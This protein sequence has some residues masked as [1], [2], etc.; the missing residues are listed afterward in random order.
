MQITKLI[1]LKFN[2]YII[3]SIRYNV[4]FFIFKYALART[5]RHTNFGGWTEK[6]SFNFLKLPNSPLAIQIPIAVKFTNIKINQCYQ[7]APGS[8]V[9]TEYD[10]SWGSVDQIKNQLFGV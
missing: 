1:Y 3:F 10:P 7:L 5:A 9:V 8:V 2:K 4:D 6:L